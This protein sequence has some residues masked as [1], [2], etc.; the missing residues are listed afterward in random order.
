MRRPINEGTGS[1]SDKPE[2]PRDSRTGRSIGDHGSAHDAIT[3]AIDIH[4]PDPGNQVEF[5]R[6]WQQGS[7]FEEWPEFYEWLADRERVL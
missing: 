6:A 7:A 5:L 4:E 1:V 2:P 3:F